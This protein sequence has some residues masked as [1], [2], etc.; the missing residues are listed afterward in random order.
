MKRA[1]LYVS[2]AFAFAATS[3][4]AFINTGLGGNT[5]YEGW[6]DLTSANYTSAM[7][8]SNF[9]PWTISSNASG[10]AGN[11]D[12]NKLSGTGFPATSSIYTLDFTDPPQSG[13]G[14]GT[15]NVTSTL[16]S[17]TNASTVVFQLDGGVDFFTAPTLNYNSGSQG[18]TFDYAATTTGLFIANGPSGPFS[19]TN[20]AFQWDLSG[21]GDTITS[22]EIV[23]TLEAHLSQYALQLETSDAAFVGTA[24]PEPSA[25]ALLA[26]TLALAFCLKRRR[27]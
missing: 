11:A 21:I 5:E 7:G 13:V 15:F 22:I 23:Y 10:S 18:I 19:T 4:N 8:Y 6:E 1:I 3:A 9:A 17:L 2:A 16:D 12:F 14:T 27:R 26:G 25:Y 24:V 20:N